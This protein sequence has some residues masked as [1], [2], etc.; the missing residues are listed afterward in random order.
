MKT[1][2][3]QDL[4]D[5]FRLAV[6]SVAPA[7]TDEEICEFLTQGQLTLVKE[8]LSMPISFPAGVLHRKDHDLN[9]EMESMAS[10]P[11]SD[12]PIYYKNLSNLDI[13][14]F[15]SAMVIV[16][17][18]DNYKY[19]S[20]INIDPQSI[21][22]FVVTVTN[23]PYLEKPVVTY[24][25]LEK[26]DV[27]YKNLIVIFGKNHNVG[28]N[29][30]YAHVEYITYPTPISVSAP[31]APIEFPELADQIVE[32]A[33]ALALKSLYEVNAF[34]AAPTQTNNQEER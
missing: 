8:L 20:T 5:K 14:K 3:A 17:D 27:D 22:K 9:T 23:T 11:Y 7:F 25:A 18:S 1:V 21:D 15:L 28:A 2:T 34:S 30:V 13:L 12:T 10:G 6:E 33:K 19:Y 32:V 4:I 16:D 29:P 24:T 31:S 26:D